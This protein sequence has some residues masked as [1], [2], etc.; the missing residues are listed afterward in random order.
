MS[1]FRGDGR[2]KESY[3]RYFLLI[4]AVILGG[5]ILIVTF[6]GELFNVSPLTFQDWVWIALIT[7]PIIIVPD[8]VRACRYLWQ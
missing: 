3:N 5:Q 8:L 7:S 4:L 2:I 1:L 6:A